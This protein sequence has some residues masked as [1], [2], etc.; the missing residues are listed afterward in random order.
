[1]NRVA[2]AVLLLLVF[3]VAAPVAAQGKAATAKGLR[4]SFSLNATGA[5]KKDGQPDAT[6]KP[7]ALVLIFE[8]IDTEDGTAKLRSGRS[9]RTSSCG[10]HPDTSISFSRFGVRSTPRRSST[11]KRPAGS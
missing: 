7:A 4:C 2:A 5:W 9:R 11:A 10:R 1:M 6:S 8:S 3:S